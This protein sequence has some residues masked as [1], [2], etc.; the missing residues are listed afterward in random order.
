MTSHTTMGGV[1]EPD[2][3][4]NG[5]DSLFPTGEETDVSREFGSPD[6]EAFCVN[7]ARNVAGIPLNLRTLNRVKIIHKRTNT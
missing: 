6:R 7:R 4:T 5:V 1:D 3:T 2:R